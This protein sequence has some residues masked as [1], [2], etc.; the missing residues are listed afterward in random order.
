MAGRPRIRWGAVR[1]F[2]DPLGFEFICHGDWF[3][4]APGDW[5]LP[6]PPGGRKRVRVGHES[7]RNANTE[8]LECYVKAV[9]T[10]FG[11]PRE[12]LLEGKLPPDWK[13]R[14]GSAGQE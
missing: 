11:I 10:A 14:P 1:R 4:V 9:C 12:A 5:E 8:M 6:S 3:I 2:L 7:S 13:R